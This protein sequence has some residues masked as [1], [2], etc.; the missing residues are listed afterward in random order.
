[1][2][3]GCISTSAKVLESLDE[4]TDPCDNFYEFACGKFLKNTVIPDDKTSIM[5][6]VTV[7]DKVT[8]QLRTILNEE[9]FLDE[10]K[11]IRIAKDFNKAC[12]NQQI[13]E[14]RGVQPLI[15]VIENYGGWPVVK[16]HDWQ[17][18]EWEWFNTQNQIVKDGL[19]D[20]LLF[21]FTVST[22]Q[23]N[24]TAR[25]MDVSRNFNENYYASLN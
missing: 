3:P 1:M 11:S 9:T 15:D 10:P 4:T 13:I 5:S 2:T 23:K 14:E 25:V 19:E 20:S 24:S 6:F 16:G 17:E 8:D 18:N 12:L 22:N 7:H 21:V